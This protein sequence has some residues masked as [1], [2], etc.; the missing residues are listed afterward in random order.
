M[1]L[2]FLKS[3]LAPLAGL[4]LALAVGAALRLMFHAD[5]EWK[6]DEQWSFIHAR[7]M[8]D[9]GSWPAVGMASSVH[10]P[11]PGLSLW[12][13]AGLAWVANAH[14][15]PDL[16]GAVQAVNVLALLAF[17]AFALV[18]VPKAR[19]EPWLWGAAL[20]AVN[21]VAIIIERKIWPPSLL[22]L[23][24]V[25]LIWAWW[26]RRN[27]LAAFAWGAL[28]ALMAQIHMGVALLA[29]ALA[30]WTLIHDRRTFPWRGWLAGSLV[31]ALPAIPWLLQLLGH[32][33]GA[34]IH[35]TAPSVSFYMRWFAQFFGYGAQYTL[36]GKAFGDYLAGPQLDGLASH[37]LLA[38]QV[39]LVLAAL[40]VLVR[41]GR[42]VLGRG[43][44]P[45]RTLLL[46]DSAET[47]LTTAAFWGYGGLLTVITFFGAGSYRHYMIVITPIMA[48]WTA[49]A[50][51]WACR[52]ARWGGA[53]TVLATLVVCQALMSVGLL[54]YIH[55]RGVI[56]GEFG[57]SWRV[58]PGLVAQ[59]AR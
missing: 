46:G 31:G 21:P 16:A 26:Y 6:A 48:L 47:V 11:N 50:V 35:L 36:G 17:A 18:A 22:P 58:R 43:R 15:P 33:S 2:Q 29:V 38:L 4:A 49:M 5:I 8:L 10:A 44:M 12:V 19:R 57:A 42:M 55:Q 52:R 41:V 9:T 45:L 32:G 54:A 3:R 20:W 53:R 25:A 23:A 37:A 51:I 27:W 30:A 34:R 39:V 14:T 24:S 59:P 40:L 28:G 56:P 1:R 13:F 7:Q